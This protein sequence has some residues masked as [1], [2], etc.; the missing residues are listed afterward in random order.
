MNS[1]FRSLRFVLGL[2]ALAL[3]LVGIPD[4]QAASL[5]SY[6]VG[7]ASPRTGTFDNVPAV[8]TTGA[9]SNILSTAIRVFPGRG[10]VVSPLVTPASASTSNIVAR[11]TVSL[12]G[13]NFTTQTINKTNVFAGTGA[14]RGLMI[15]TPLELDNVH[16]IRLESM[17]QYHTGSAYVTNVTWSVHGQGN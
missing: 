8:I 7:P 1:R 6:A 13:S 3:F 10:L 9:T 15:F 2:V 5:S 16:S 17:S 4:V 12:D 14:V 11:F